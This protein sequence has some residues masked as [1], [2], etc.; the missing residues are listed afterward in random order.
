MIVVWIFLGIVVLVLLAG[1]LAFRV[2][3]VPTKPAPLDDP[4]AMEKRLKPTHFRLLQEGMAWLRE[5]PAQEVSMT[6]FD[7]LR[8][9]GRWIPAENARGTILM[10]HGWHGCPE[11]DFCCIFSVYHQLGL[12]LL[13]VD[14]RAQNDR[15]GKH[16]TFGVKESR[17]CADWVRFHNQMF[18]PQPVILDGISMGA[19]TVLLAMGQ[20]LPDNVRGVV[21]DS[22]Y[23]SAWDIFRSVARSVHVPSFPI[24]HAAR[25]WCV[26]LAGFDPRAH[27]TEKAMANSRLPVLLIHGLADNFVP[28]H[29][30]Q[31]AYD[32]YQG[33]KELILVENATH[34]MGYVTEPERCRKALEEFFDRVLQ[35]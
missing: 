6:S 31:R 16:I 8:L 7:G 1:W 4:Q 19:S 18:G 14:Q 12:N 13:F 27:S 30:S 5:H 34:G 2:A 24:L 20:E 21:A 23:T 26:L 25:L 9:R 22:G 15:E 32:A 29:M 3:C 33:P 10:F 17:D 35:P 28:S 11:T